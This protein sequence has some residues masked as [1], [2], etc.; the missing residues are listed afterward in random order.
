[1]KHGKKTLLAIA[2]GAA[3]L[4]LSAMADRGLYFGGSVGTAELSEDFG[5]IG[6]DADSTAYR[7]VVGWQLSDFLSLEGGY[8]DFGRFEDA[9]TVGGQPVNLRLKADGFTLGGTAS[10]P[11]SYS[12]SLYG[13]AG[14]FFWDGDAEVNSITDARP[15]DTNPYFGGGAKVSL[16][17]R[18]D[19]IGDWTRYELDETESDV[20]SLGF[21]VRF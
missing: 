18:I 8:Q 14:A 9:F 5:G 19:L 3:L 4:P 16:T 10:I 2:V 7:L 6:I 1:M 12:M 20:I 17:N 21:T 13:R 15:E 11:L